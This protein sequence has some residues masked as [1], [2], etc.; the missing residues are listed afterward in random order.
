M[1]QSVAVGASTAPGARPEGEARWPVIAAFVTAWVFPATTAKRTSQASLWRV[2]LVHLAAA[3]LTAASIVYVKV[4]SEAGPLLA[5]WEIMLEVD[6]MLT[7][8]GGEIERHP[9]RFPLTVAGTVLFI[10][11]SLLG[12]ALLVMPWGARDEP[13]RESYRNALRQTWLRTVHVIPIVFLVGAFAINLDRLQ[14][15]W[16]IE[17]QAP[18]GPAYPAYPSLPSVPA[19]DPSYAQAMADYDVAMQ[20][21][22]QNTAKAQS[23]WNKWH[24][25][26][27]WYIRYEV[28]LIVSLCFAMALWVLW[29]L[30][31]GVGATRAT[32]PIARPPLCEECGYNLTTIPM[33]SR[34]PEC[35]ASVLASLGPNA[36]PGAVWRRRGDVG[37]LSAWWRSVIESIRSP[38]KLGRQLQLV[39]PGSDHRR[40]FALHLP[41][42]FG[43]GFVGGAG[44]VTVGMGAQEIWEELPIMIIALSMFSCACVIGAVGFALSAALLAGLV[45]S[46]RHRRNLLPGSMQV[47][48][49]LSGYLVM[50]ALFGAAS[51]V[52]TMMLGNT[53]WFHA[54]EKITWINRE[55]LAFMAWFLPNA[56]CGIG[57]LILLG[58]GTMCT[59]YANR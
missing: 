54:L 3:L 59:R 21:Y 7:A 57:Y 39:A 14:A 13:L 47:A 29:A 38:A 2:W 43:V 31:R 27:P 30:L 17:H 53:W 51:G 9:V 20:E 34:C 8:I 18:D 24:R 52:I 12:I 32:A 16:L 36:R 41:I 58:R 44:A 5:L 35:G 6:E 19:N 45:Q 40:F 48:S 4:W 49:Y 23:I 1:N 26:L 15:N 28:P 42:I 55:K 25:N 50:W 33:E 11:V 37:R 22:Q 56:A 46:L 10:E